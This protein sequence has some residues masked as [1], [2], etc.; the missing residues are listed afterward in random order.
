M[1]DILQPEGWPRP[2]GYSNGMAATGR[3]I[4]ISGQVGWDAQCRFVGD[5]M[6]VQVGQALANIVTILKVAG[7]TPQHI[8][9]LTWFVTSRDEYNSQLKEIGA[10]YRSVMGKHFPTMSVVQVA[11]LMEK[12]AKVEIE[13]TAVV[14][15]P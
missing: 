4:F 13:A 7:A 14:P 6:A 11:G 8:V 15:Q 10:A 3:T 1:I 2:K 5:T 12:E 9:R